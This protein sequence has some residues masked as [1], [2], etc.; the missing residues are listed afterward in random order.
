MST[1]CRN[2]MELEAAQEITRFFNGKK[3]MFQ[4]PKKEYENSI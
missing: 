3:L 2:K 4:V 1:S